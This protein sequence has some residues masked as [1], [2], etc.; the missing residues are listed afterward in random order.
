MNS[1]SAWQTRI[2]SSATTA[3]RRR[4]STR[5]AHV[6]FPL[7]TLSLFRSLSNAN[8]NTTEDYLDTFSGN[9]DD[10]FRFGVSLTKKTIKLFAE[11]YNSDIIIASPLGLR[12]LVGA[13]GYILA[14][15]HY[16]R[17]NERAPHFSPPQ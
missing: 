4:R 13:P 12:M 9:I 2:G 3:W 6:L 1:R 15:E 10:C 16:A 17:Y 7:L 5:T 14:L 11:F 8:T